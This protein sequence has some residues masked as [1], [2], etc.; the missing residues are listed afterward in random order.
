M[1]LHFS[2][3]EKQAE[4]IDDEHYKLI[5]KYDKDDETELVIRILS[6]GPMVKVIE[7]YNFVELIKKRL[8]MQKSCGL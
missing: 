1:L 6:F 3:F 2:H 7:P 8:E 5:L 4:K